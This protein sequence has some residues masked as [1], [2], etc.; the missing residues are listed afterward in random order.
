MTGTKDRLSPIGWARDNGPEPGA[1]VKLRL[2][3]GHRAWRTV[4]QGEGPNVARQWFISG[5]PL[6]GEI[7]PISAIRADRGGEVVVAA[8]SFRHDAHDT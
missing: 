5:N 7:T 1:E 8:E 2:R 6:L 3:Y 4:A